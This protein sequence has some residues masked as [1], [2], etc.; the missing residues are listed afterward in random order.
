MSVTSSI[1]KDL[2]YSDE[3]ALREFAFLQASQKYAE[4][5]LEDSFFEQKY[6]SPFLEFEKSLK[7]MS[8]ERFEV[9]DDYLAWRF[10]H[11]GMQYWQ[12]QL[13]ILRRAP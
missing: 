2:G 6:Q 3:K 11:E 12:T 8:E 13:D 10:A 1:L 5:K 9:E 4:L 7:S